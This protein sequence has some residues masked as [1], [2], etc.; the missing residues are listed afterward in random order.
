MSS[1][2]TV[3]K[4]GMKIIDMNGGHF[5]INDV[6]IIAPF[7]LLKRTEYDGYFLG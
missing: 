7:W 2:Y 4:Y 3:F 6:E 5:A 1:E